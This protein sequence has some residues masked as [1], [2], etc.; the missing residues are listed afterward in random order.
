MIKK[1]LLLVLLLFCKEAYPQTSAKN[2]SI[3]SLRLLV[4]TTTNDTLK[5]ELYHQ[6]CKKNYP[7]NSAQIK[8]YSKKLYALSKKIHY[9]KGFGLY[10]L[11]QTDIDYLEGNFEKAV[12]D[13]EKAYTILSKTTDRENHLNA[14]SY[15]AYAY[16]DNSDYLKARKLL[17][18]NMPMARAYGNPKIVGRLY[19]FLGESYEDETSTSEELK[20]YKKSLYHYNQTNDV[21]GKASLYQRIAYVYKRIAL[22]KEALNYL[23]LALDLQPDDYNYTIILV[24]K[25]RVYNKLERY[26]DAK[27][28]E[29]TCAKK[30]VQNQQYASDI[31][32]VNKLCLAISN[33]GLKE[34]QAAISNCREIL[35]T[36]L[37]AQTKMS[38]LNILSHSY[39]KTNRLDLAKRY[40][41]QSMALVD[42]VNDDGLENTF[43]IKSE[44]EE[45]LGN[46]KTALV[47]SQKYNALSDEKNEK[48]NQNKLYYLQVDF[49]VS[50]KENKIKNL[51][52][53]D[54]QKT[55]DLKQHKLFLLLLSFIIFVVLVLL[56]FFVKVSKSIKKR[57][58]LIEMANT[59]LSKAQIETQKALHE[60]E[61]LLKEIHHR[62][63]NNFQ[64]VLSL[65][66][67]QAREG[68]EQDIKHFL[69][70]GQSR[71]M[72]MALIH[73]NLY[74]T[75]RLDEVHFQEYIENLVQTIDGTYPHPSGKINTRVNA[76]EISF[77]IQTSIPLG[78]IINE[79]YSNSLKHAFPTEKG[80][81]VLI[82]LKRTNATNFRLIVADNGIGSKRTT[83][84][85]KTLGLELVDLL[86][87]QLNGTI[88]T[89][90]NQGTKYT[91][92]FSEVIS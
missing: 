80:G 28:I 40:I 36:D 4:A 63:K 24:E 52:I 30:I 42:Q 26:A 38:A 41:D 27:K 57:N 21:L 49:D 90:N 2:K 15:L 23:N 87:M 16:L 29:L 78:L 72:S 31:Y 6:L 50:E 70:K 85:K 14:V 25:A 61:L 65:L 74:Q 60:R 5:I 17:E 77:D 20:C 92:D 62:V 88:H 66:N 79:L 22:Y 13:G 10:Y 83:K 69:A 56:F 91:I 48:I 39:L 68:E 43:K 89:E 35:A 45:A 73:E 67:I 46:Y 81:E 44:V 64:L 8:F 7:E 19:L 1:I 71:I 32:W 34:Y 58:L 33:F 55:L 37:D 53:V 76:Y 11:N 3:D 84:K 18:Q 75:D 82:E 86:V 59:D 51:K 12:A 9:P 54:L 47:Y